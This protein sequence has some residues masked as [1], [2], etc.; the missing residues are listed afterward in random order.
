M[1]KLSFAA[2]AVAFSLFLAAPSWAQTGMG[3]NLQY[4]MDMEEFQ[5]GAELIVPVGVPG[6][7]FVPN[8]E[9]YLRDRP[10]MWSAN[11]DFHYYIGEA[12]TRVFTP[13]VGLGLAVTRASAGGTGN[14]EAGM[15][16]KGG[17]DFRT[18]SATPFFQIEYRTGR[19]DDLSVGGGVR[20]RF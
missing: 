19:Y 18:G 17:A 6:V 7:V 8:F 10:T 11:G 20:F 1:K 9:L 3:V 4:G 2:T 12:Y 14:T 16:I 5:A 15:N 13:Y